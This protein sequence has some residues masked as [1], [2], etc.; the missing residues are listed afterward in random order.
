MAAVHFGHKRVVRL[1]EGE[2][3]KIKTRFW[4][5]DC[6]NTYQN[7]LKRCII[8]KSHIIFFIGLNTTFFFILIYYISVRMYS[9]V[10]LCCS[11]L[12]MLV[13][14]YELWTTGFWSTGLSS[15]YLCVF[16]LPIHKKSLVI[17]TNLTSVTAKLFIFFYPDLLHKR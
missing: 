17:H 14:A 16:L 4:Q 3:N 2:F 6:Q 13:P 11:P 5:T 9:C 15:G 7:W 8:I 1:D 12:C 10:F